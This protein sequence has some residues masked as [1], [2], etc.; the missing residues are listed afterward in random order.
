MEGEEDTGQWGARRWPRCRRRRR[1]RRTAASGPRVPGRRG[2]SSSA[3]ADPGSGR[4]ALAPDRPAAT[5]TQSRGEGLDRRDLWRTRRRGGR[6]IHD[7]GHAA[8]AR[9][10]GEEV[11]ERGQSSPATT[12]ARTTVNQRPSQ[13]RCGFEV[14]RGGRVVRVPAGRSAGVRMKASGTGRRTPPTRLRTTMATTSSPPDVLGPGRPDRAV[15]FVSRASPGRRWRWQTTYV[16]YAMIASCHR[17]AGDD[18]TGPGGGGLAG[19]EH[20]RLR[21]G[22]AHGAADLRRRVG[23]VG[24]RGRGDR[25]AHPVPHSVPPAAAARP[26]SKL[27]PGLASTP[28]RRSVRSTGSSPSTW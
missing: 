12:G 23:P 10:P 8:P 19:S 2:R 13:G 27:R 11:D 22:S 17:Q 4:S 26:S 25:D 21:D 3:E 9:L 7:L 15:R 18:A 14:A 6:G 16:Q 28:P 20:R 1:R 5:D 24:G